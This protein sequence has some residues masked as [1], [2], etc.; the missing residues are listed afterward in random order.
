MASSGKKPRNGESGQAAVESALTLPLV[1]FLF[2]GT[3][4]LFM[5]LQARIMTQYAAFRATRAGSVNNGNCERMM[6][7]AIAAL[8]PTMERT[9]TPDALAAAFSAHRNNKLAPLPGFNGDMIW[10]IREQPTNVNADDLNFDQGLAPPM[11][12]EVRLVYWYPMRIPFANWVMTKM[13]RAHFAIQDYTAANPLI[14][15]EKNANWT[16]SANSTME[17]QILGEYTSRSANEFIFPITASY[18]MRMMTPA[19]Q[20]YFSQQNCAP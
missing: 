18:S 13:F 1:I 8:L 2:L 11:R 20:Q 10:L 14:L 12:L 7:A 6:H 17:A 16:T 3:L 9:N 5:M 4:Q 19:L 15:A